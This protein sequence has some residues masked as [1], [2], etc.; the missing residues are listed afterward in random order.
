MLSRLT[1]PNYKDGLLGAPCSL[2]Q[3][4]ELDCNV[5]ISPAPS[6]AYLIVILAATFTLAHQIFIRLRNP[7]TMEVAMK[8]LVTQLE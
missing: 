8:P 5:N 4:K 1:K 3:V 6:S 2:A 7:H